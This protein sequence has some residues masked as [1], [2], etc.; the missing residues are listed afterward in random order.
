[1]RSVNLR[2]QVARPLRG[3]SFARIDLIPRELLFA[4]SVLVL[5]CHCD[6]LL[7][8]RFVLCS[9][10]VSL[11]YPLQGR[12]AFLSRRIV[13]ANAY[14]DTGPPTRASK[15]C[16]Q[17]IGHGNWLV[18]GSAL[19]SVRSHCL[20]ARVSVSLYCAPLLRRLGYV[21]CDG[22]APSAFFTASVC[23]VWTCVCMLQDRRGAFHLRR[24]ISRHLS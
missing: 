17:R 2:T 4:A 5:R 6:V 8:V 15:Y 9:L 18:H 19:R 3:I 24:L 11:R 23:V 12:G 16:F 13:P 22:N 14:T 20:A 1:M 7:P 21:C 10:C